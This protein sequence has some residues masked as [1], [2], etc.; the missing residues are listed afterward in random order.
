ME[1][2]TNILLEKSENVKKVLD[3]MDPVMESA[4]YDSGMLNVAT[5]SNGRVFIP[6]ERNYRQEIADFMRKF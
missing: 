5:E 6:V 1:S 4:S 2:F 3:S